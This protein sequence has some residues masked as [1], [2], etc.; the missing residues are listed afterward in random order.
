[1]V[2][3]H[4]I[5]TLFMGF[6]KII[7]V[8]DSDAYKLRTFPNWFMTFVSLYG[9]GFQLL[10]IALMLALIYLVCPFFLSLF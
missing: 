1:M 6:D 2:V 10:L 8:M 3:L 5:Y 9:L 7:H 4:F